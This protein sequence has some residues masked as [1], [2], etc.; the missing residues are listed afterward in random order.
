[1]SAQQLAEEIESLI[2]STS[3]TF[4]AEVERLQG[5][6]Y[7][8]IAVSL[9]ELE[10]DADGY[11]LQNANNRRILYNAENLIDDLL[12]GEDLTHTVS[13]SLVAIPQI[14]TLNETYFY[15]VSKSFNPNRNFLKAL[16]GQ[17]IER[18]EATMLQD[19]LTAAIKLPLK[20]ILVQNV[21][22]GG[23]F[24]GMLQQVRN[25][26]QGDEDL[27]GRLL[28]YS[29]GILRDTLFTYSRSYQQAV[30]ADLKLEYYMYSGGIIDKT[31][32]FCAERSGNFYHESEIKKWAD[33]DW[34]GKRAGTTESSIFIYCGGYNCAHSLV[35]VDKSI[36]P[37]ES[38]IS[39]GR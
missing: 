1:M 6:V 29:R 34:Q 17:T 13:N 2:I 28:S 15:G 18:I 26:I 8:R 31:R 27:D 11:I 38:L 4:A 35:P 12:P 14:E 24:S 23:S 19:G 25:F 20:D 39:S 9:K 22:T 10:L 37:K 21:N 32:P 36:V 33:L 5:I 16:Q 7:N 30:T 3:E